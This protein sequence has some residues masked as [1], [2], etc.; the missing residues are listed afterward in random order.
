MSM[1]PQERRKDD[2]TWLYVA[3][4]FAAFWG[5][6]LIFF[7]PKGPSGAPMLGGS[8]LLIPADYV[9]KATDL[10]GKPVDFAA[11]QGKP[12]FLNIWATWCPPCR[13]EMPSIAKLAADPRIKGKVEIVCISTDNDRDTVKKFVAD[14]AWPM[15]LLHT[16]Q[17]PEV[18]QTQGI[19]ATFLIDRSG[20]IVAHEVGSA[21]WDSTEVVDFLAKMADEPQKR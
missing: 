9:W 19:P 6:Y 1:N 12:V 13:A 15:T 18:F 16:N 5:I 20:R 8:G 17:V 14:K 4:A 3:L 10:D 11:Y 21:N 2:R 7:N